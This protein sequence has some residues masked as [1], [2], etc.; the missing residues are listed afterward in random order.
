[1]PPFDQPLFDTFY[2]GPPESE[3]PGRYLH[4]FAPQPS[5]DGRYLALPGIGGYDHPSGD[6]GVGFWLADLATGDLRQLWPQARPFTWSPDSQALTFA[7]DDVL[8]TL[9]VTDETAVPTPLF[10][11]P[12]LVDLWVRW[13]PDGRWIAAVTLEAAGVDETGYPLQTEVLWLVP[14]NGEPAFELARRPH[15]AMEHVASEIT[16][17]PDSQYLLLHQE[18]INLA[19]DTVWPQTQG[20]ATWRPGHNQLLVNQADGMRL[21]TV[22][23]EEFYRISQ[24]W[25]EDWALSHDGRQLAYVRPGNETDIFLFNLETGEQQFAGSIAGDKVGS[26]RWTADDAYLII[27]G[28]QAL[29]PIW[30]MAAQPGSPARP[31]AAKG[32]LIDVMGLQGT[33]VPTQ[34][35]GWLPYQ[36]EGFSL[37]YPALWTVSEQDNLTYFLS[38]ESFGEGPQPL[39]YYVYTTEYANP[40]GRPFPEVVTAG[41]SQELQQTFTYTQEAIGPYTVYR[42]TM[43]PSAEGALT[44]F[45]EDDG[46]Y[47]SLALTPY[48]AQNPFP[49]QTQYEQL[50]SQLL[51][52]VRLTLR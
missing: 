52:T 33:A 15:W 26:L 17:S 42:T 43:I 45:F 25:L 47:L 5:P 50:F 30:L 29:T 23:G 22:S 24:E 9:D 44:L 48:N 51:E 2:G 49:A 32:L 3:Q 19:G 38:N 11:H 34:T 35:T 6:L 41:L 20:W 14:T 4:N 1:V 37:Q 21:M 28:E 10:T 13:S 7:D 12:V 27:D 18:V 36:G 39:K 31:L 46:R 16:W 8:Y 40:E